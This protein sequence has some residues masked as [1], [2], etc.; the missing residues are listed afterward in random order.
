M[1]K[2]Q[3]V[4]ELN[5]YLGNDTCL[6]VNDDEEHGR[7]FVIITIENDAVVNIDHGYPSRKAAE[8][9]LA[10]LADLAEMRAQ[11]LAERGGDYGK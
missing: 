4:A 10:D 2:K 1:A 5:S 6:V 7:M 3:L 8:E 11:V 9:I